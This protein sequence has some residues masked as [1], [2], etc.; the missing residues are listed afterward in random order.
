MENFFLALSGDLGLTVA[1]ENLPQAPTPEPAADTSL[2]DLQ[3]Q[4]QP[5]FQDLEMQF[6]AALPAIGWGAR[7]IETVRS[8]ERQQW[9]YG[10]G[11]QYQAPGRTGIVT[12]ASTPS[13][14]HVEGRA[15]DYLYVNAGGGDPDA[16][17]AAL[18]TI[19][20]SMPNLTWGGNFLTLS[21]PPHWEGNA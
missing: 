19:A 4:W 11:R 12:N 2:S 20:A 15:V 16:L 21:D 14:P 5:V 17:T 9:L 1:Y 13:G 8:L 10:I 3:P 18:K 7:R 6:A